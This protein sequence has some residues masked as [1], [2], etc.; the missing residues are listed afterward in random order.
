[1][2]AQTEGAKFWLSVL[3]ELKT[4]GLNDILIACVDGLILY[5]MIGSQ[6]LTLHPVHVGTLACATLG[7]G[8]LTQSQASA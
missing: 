6:H 1:M 3:S 8:A 5:F 7:P 2:V 4:R